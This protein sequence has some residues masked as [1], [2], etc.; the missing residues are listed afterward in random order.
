MVEDPKAVAGFS[1]R[2]WSQLKHEAA[3]GVR[4][5]ATAGEGG[6]ATFPPAAPPDAGAVP[7]TAGPVSLPPVDTLTFESDFSVFMQPKVEDATRR[8]ALKKLFGDPSFNVMDGL[9]IY[10]GDY[11]QADPMPAGMLEKLA[12]VYGALDVTENDAGGTAR[13]PDSA[14]PMLSAPVSAPIVIGAPSDAG[15]D[16][17][18]PDAVAPGPPAIATAEVPLCAAVNLPSD[19]DG[20]SKPA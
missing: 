12:G 4:Q 10:V 7:P 16:V 20:T 6:A 8:A 18:A 19:A 11:T 14:G 3:R 15:A 1:L 17:T 2:R 13:A 5:E 9:D